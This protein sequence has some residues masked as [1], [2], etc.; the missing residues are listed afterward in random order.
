M[1]TL[2][3]PDIKKVGSGR[4]EIITNKVFSGKKDANIFET[5]RGPFY[6]SGI[7][8]AGFEY[9]GKASTADKK[10]YAK[11]I[12]TLIHNATRAADLGDFDL[13]GKFNNRGSIFAV[14]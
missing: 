10:K 4:P 3:F 5:D 6:A 1:A 2:K 7:L 9:P 8:I 14:K 12:H 11:E 13:I